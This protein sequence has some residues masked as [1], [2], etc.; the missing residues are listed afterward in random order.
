[1]RLS[2][3]PFKRGLKNGI[4]PV[5][6]NI[7]FFVA[8][9]NLYRNKLRTGLTIFGITI[10][11][12]AI[13][14]LTSFGLGLQDLVT[15][16]VIGDKS[17]KAVDI[18]SPNSK[19]I[20]L[21]DKTTNKLSN[22]GSVKK[23]GRSYSF[24]GSLTYKGA[25]LDM[26]TYGVDENYQGL[27]SLN[28]VA[29]RLL[30]NTDN[31]QIIMNR[32][33][34]TALGIKEDK[35]AIDRAVKL[36]IP[37]T[38]LKTDQKEIED[39]F[40]IVGVVNSGAGGEVFIPRGKFDSA[41]IPYYSQVKVV[42]DDTKNVPAL[43]KQ[44]ESMGFETTSPIDTLGQI[45][46]IFKFFTIILASFGA[47]GMVVSVLGMFN[48][49]TISL[50][51][52]TQEI[53]LM[54]SMGARNRDIRTLFVL[55]A[56]ILSITGAVV[57]ILIAVVTGKFVNLVMNIFAHQRGVPGSFELFSTPLWLM[58]VMVVFMVI[59]GN[60]VVHFPAKRAAKIN[61]IDALRRE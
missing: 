48:T 14:F 56:L 24:P 9:N 57:G 19:I 5:S 54:M 18:T 50:L 12:S 17:I 58:G 45:N 22:L 28:L 35:D 47:I 37:L 43:R 40:T 4:K 53:G 26:V 61:P 44:I 11:I 29:G 21:D 42:V 39:T 34:L 15:E 10:G 31:N 8:Y 60:L 52:R 25:E 33:A 55:E 7:L 41:G 20:K 59:V 6:L 1:M 49:L 46:E 27:S 13:F 23:V 51:E 3:N 32:A 38:G 36:T 2:L 30:K 16:Q